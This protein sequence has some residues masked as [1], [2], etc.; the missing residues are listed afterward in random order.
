MISV[1]TT[2]WRR[3]PLLLL[4]TTPSGSRIRCA[5]QVRAFTRAERVR[6]EPLEMPAFYCVYLLRSTV[7][8]KSFYIGS[9]PDPRRRLA[10]HNG[11]AKGGAARTSRENLRPWEMTCIVSG[12]TSAVAALQFEWAW[13]NPD[14]TSKIEKSQRISKSIHT[15]TNLGRTRIISPRTGVKTLLANLH[16]LMRVPAFGR[17]PLSVRFFAEDLYVGWEA[18]CRTKCSP[19]KAVEVKL[20]L[21]KSESSRSPSPPPNNRRMGGK[22]ERFPPTGEGGLQGLDITNDHLD[23][24]MQ[25]ARDLLRDED[26]KCGVCAGGVSHDGGATAVVCPH[27]FCNH[28]AHLKCLSQVFLQADASYAVLPTEGLCPECKRSTKWVDL[29]RELSSRTRRRPEATKQKSASA[30]GTVGREDEEDCEEE[31]AEM[32]LMLSDNELGLY[33]IVAHVSDSVGSISTSDSDSDSDSDSGASNRSKGSAG[34]SKKKRLGN[35]N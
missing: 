1:P 16:L 31:E 21:R 30:V 15:K 34:K 19:L 22:V 27:A 23:R 8:P 13:Q 28:V 35:K 20:D 25:K 17:W 33:G 6:M 2:I 11:E 26:I 24:H 32:D 3:S 4:L 10:Q 7:R 18:H 5:A 29:V 14:K 9:T 12:F